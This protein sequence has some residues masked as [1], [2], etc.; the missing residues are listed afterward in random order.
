MDRLFEVC[1]SK[2]K[3]PLISSDFPEDPTAPIA[4]AIAI[5]DGVNR[6]LVRE[7]FQSPLE[8][9]RSHPQ[10]VLIAQWMVLL[11]PPDIRQKFSLGRLPSSLAQRMKELPLACAGLL[12]PSRLFRYGAGPRGERSSWSGLLRMPW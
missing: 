1:C 9:V 11:D 3:L 4:D 5:L 6:L 10:A 2:E 12:V 7:L 8:L